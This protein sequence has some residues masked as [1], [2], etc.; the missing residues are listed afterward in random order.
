MKRTLLLAV[1]I[2]V[3]GAAFLPLFPRRSAAPAPAPIPVPA[4]QGRPIPAPAIPVDRERVTVWNVLAVENRPEA[5]QAV[6]AELRK[7]CREEPGAWERAA[8]MLRAEGTTP[9]LRQALALVL[10]TLDRPGTDALL[11]EVLAM[12][13]TDAALARCLLLALGATREPEEDDD[14]FGLGDRPWGA[15]GP[16]GIGITVRR[17]IGDAAV[18]AAL[19]G[20]LGRAEI[21]VREA[22]A[23]ALRHSLDAA[24]ARAGFTA[25][26]A[27]EASDEV[28]PVLGEGL[29]VRAGTT[30]D[31]AERTEIVAALLARAGDAGLDAFRFRIE[32]DFARIPL[33]E[34]DRRAL[35]ALASDAYPLG[36]RLFALT[37]LSR[38]APAEARPLLSRLVGGDPD[39]AI[40]DN[41]ARL[42][43]RASP[44]EAEVAVLARAALKDAAWNVRFTAME[45]V[46][47]RAPRPLALETLQAARSDADSRVAALAAERLQRLSR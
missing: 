12:P 40:R 25:A 45:A 31:P 42:L 28:A 7:R 6:A 20:A 44:G 10:G 1:A 32:N 21:P 37:A 39:A 27:R 29:A 9:E 18:R 26:L 3:A 16:G 8:A 43:G 30:E 2:L 38:A 17:R 5:R 13:G 35:E 4:P 41:A 47:D 14:V 19:A 36:T 15:K 11:L 34:A 46:A 23:V 33:G 22:A 24:D